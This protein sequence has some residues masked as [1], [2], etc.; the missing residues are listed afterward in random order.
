M[1]AAA[2]GIARHGGLLPFV[3]T[4]LVFSD[5]ARPAMRLAAIQGTHVIFAFTHDSIGVGEDGPTHQPI[6]QLASFRAMPGLQVL[7]PAD[8][9]ETVACWKLALE[10]QGPTLLALSRQALPVL[11]EMERIRAG[12]PRGAYTFAD[13][14]SGDPDVILIA[15]GSEVAVALGA[16]DLLRREGI[17]A[18]VVSM[19]GWSIF[20]AQ[21]AEYRN[22]VL[23]PAVRARV[24]IEAGASL[25][26]RQWVGEHGDIVAL[27][28]FG[29]SA[30]GEVLF[31]K[32]GFSPEA[33]AARARAVF[34][35]V[36]RGVD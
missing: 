12:V 7:R 35:R 17:A 34:A 22:D 31:G 20:E 30:P 15:T 6:E 19:P 1:A 36:Q 8:A 32:L 10:F 11:G 14:E 33:V 27:D 24:S 18:R 9:N 13:A 25:G 28:R 16:R 26:W 5:Y 2:N 23:P 21:S 4:Y 3:A 29:A